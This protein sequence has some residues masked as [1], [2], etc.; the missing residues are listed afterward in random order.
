MSLGGDQEP[1][2]GMEPDVTTFSFPLPKPEVVP[3][4]NIRSEDLHGPG[5]IFDVPHCDIDVIQC[6]HH[7]QQFRPLYMIHEDWQAGWRGVDEVIG[8]RARAQP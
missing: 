8:D 4:D 3:A 6:G 7:L 1:S 2:L 5:C